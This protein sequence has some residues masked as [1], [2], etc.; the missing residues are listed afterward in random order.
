MHCHRNSHVGLNIEC[1]VTVIRSAVLLQSW[2]K[3][4]IT[5]FGSIRPTGL[6]PL[7]ADRPIGVTVTAKPCKRTRKRT[8]LLRL[9]LR[10]QQ[11]TSE[12][13][14]LLEQRKIRNGRFLPFAQQTHTT[15]RNMPARCR[16]NPLSHQNPSEKPRALGRTLPK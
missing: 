2:R 10:L 3:W 16:H 14:V 15:T 6:S 13:D 12:W 1:T 11:R 7:S 4:R 8:P 5:A 9:E